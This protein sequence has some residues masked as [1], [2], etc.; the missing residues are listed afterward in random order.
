M[1]A[2]GR[3]LRAVAAAALASTGAGCE[4]PAVRGVVADRADGA[5]IAGAVVVELWRE[6][7]WL[8]EPARAE[9][10]RFATSDAAGRFELPAEAGLLFGAE[11]PPVY[12]LAHPAY[13]LVHAG[14]VAP[15]AGVVELRVGR[16]QVVSEQAFAALCETPPR[17]DW[18]RRLASQICR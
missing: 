9:R 10:A 17:E 11:R 4:L 7:G 14:E 2:A 15:V 18:E 1:R 3:L 8:G 16:G 6:A 13:G 5:P 12:V